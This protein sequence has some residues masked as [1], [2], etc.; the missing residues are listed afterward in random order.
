M[1]KYGDNKC[2]ECK[3]NRRCYMQAV[4][5]E[6][7]GVE[8]ICPKDETMEQE[9][10]R[11]HNI[12]DNIGYQ[13]EGIIKETENIGISKAT[14]E[15]LAKHNIELLKKIFKMIVNKDVSIMGDKE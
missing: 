2:L 14:G 15:M 13:I 10:E 5:C 11:L 4:G 7:Y 1:T 6:Q 9:N 12:L 3:E 8:F